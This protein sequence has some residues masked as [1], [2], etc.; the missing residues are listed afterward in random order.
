[1]KRPLGGMLAVFPTNIRLFLFG[2]GE[3][4]RHYPKRIREFALGGQCHAP[5]FLRLHAE[6]ALELHDLAQIAFDFD[7]A[8]HKGGHGVEFACGHGG[9][10]GA[11]HDEGGAGSF[12][13]AFT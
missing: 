4:A 3:G 5:D 7:F 6:D 10:I 9:V 11:V 12:D 2:G 13:G 8:G 1:M